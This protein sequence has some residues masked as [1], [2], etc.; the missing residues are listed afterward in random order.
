MKRVRQKSR[1]K[2]K[3]RLQSHKRSVLGIC[4]VLV[5][6]VLVVSVG[7]ISLQKKNQ[8]YMAQEEELIAQ[9]EEE[10]ARTEEIEELEAYVGT[11]EYVEQIAKDKLGLVYE[12]E[13]I[14][15][16]K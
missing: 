12:D 3:N 15:K 13:I 1:A 2:Q 16:S 8:E 4:T 14:F 9:I 5:L 10:K 7:S 11:E 6:L